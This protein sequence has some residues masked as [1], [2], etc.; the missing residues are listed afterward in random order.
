MSLSRGKYIKGDLR[1]VTLE[2]QG[3]MVLE[4]KNESQREM[5]EGF[6]DKHDSKNS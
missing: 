2:P 4:D 1:K 6:T 5:K 3:A